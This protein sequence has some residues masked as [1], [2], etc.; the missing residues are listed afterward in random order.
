MFGSERTT[1]AN[2]T[3]RGEAIAR[4]NDQLRKT[5]RGGHIMVTRVVRGLPGFSACV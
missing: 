1:I 3:P 2:D 4:L 5:T